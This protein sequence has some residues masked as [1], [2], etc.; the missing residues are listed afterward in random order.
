MSQFCCQ[1][2]K[3]VSGALKPRYCICCGLK[4]AA[5]LCGPNPTLVRTVL[6]WVPLEQL[7]PDDVPILPE[8]GEE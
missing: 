6:P 5:C 8:E 2:G 3:D 7:G 1:C 4:A